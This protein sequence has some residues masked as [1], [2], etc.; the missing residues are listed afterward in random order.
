MAEKSIHQ[1][2]KMIDDLTKS[3]EASRRLS[4]ERHE[5]YKKNDAD[6]SKALGDLQKTIE[7]YIRQDIADK[8]EAKQWRKDVT[9]SIEVMKSLQSW[10][11][12]TA[13]LLKTIILLGSAI[14]AVYGLWI[15]IK[16]NI[17]N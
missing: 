15:F 3:T 9:P 13:W 10:T 2:E 16:H 7:D 4:E 5:S 11:S 12:T 14:G 17:N 6:H 1:L 8:E